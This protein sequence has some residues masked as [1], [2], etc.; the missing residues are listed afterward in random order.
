MSKRAV[1]YAVAAATVAG[2]CAGTGMPDGSPA[3][4]RMELLQRARSGRAPVPVLVQALADENVIVRRTAARLLGELG[5]PAASA[6]GATQEDSDAL[7][8]RIGLMAICRRGG[9][10]AL[11]AVEEALQLVG[12]IL[13]DE[14]Y[15][16]ADIGA[17]RGRELGVAVAESMITFEKHIGF[18]TTL[19]EVPGFS[20]EHIERALE[21]AKNPQLRMKLENMPVSLTA[22]SVDEYMGSVLISA[23]T[24][25]LGTIKNV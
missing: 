1:V 13:Q 24:G 20:S 8:R 14:G 16:N 10:E 25:D 15:T 12:K 7:V 11:P 22:E 9:A 4:R 17:L 5:E 6:L 2:A 19:G 23:Q 21:A 3:Q 18:P